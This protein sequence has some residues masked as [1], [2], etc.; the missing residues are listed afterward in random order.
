[1]DT[2]NRRIRPRLLAFAAAAFGLGA[3]LA[4]S[5]EPPQCLH[6]L[7]DYQYCRDSGNDYGT[8]SGYYS[9]CMLASGCPAGLP[10][11]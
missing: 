4:A 10:P 8:C 6:C 11:L 2:R 1:M 5:A 7:Q 3:A 9:N